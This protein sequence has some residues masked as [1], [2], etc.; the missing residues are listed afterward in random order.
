MTGDLDL[1]TKEPE[2]H[3]WRVCKIK[4]HPYYSSHDVKNDIAL[5][6]LCLQV[7]LSYAVQPIAL[8]ERRNAVHAGD[9]TTVAGWG[10][11]T[12][13]GR[14]SSILKY[15][16]VEVFSETECRRAYPW[17]TKNQICAGIKQGGKDSCQGDSGGPLW[18]IDP[19]S[20]IRRLV[21]IVS[22]GKGC[23][24]KSFPGVYTKVS[25][26]FDWILETMASGL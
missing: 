20:R 10:V 5:L 1:N 19:N 25:A 7:R 6:K 9:R 4:I 13:G 3:I 26:Y 2:E 11:L 21:G 16:P 24:R 12:E 8:S 23:A 18:W 15:V 17:V 14:L 22:N